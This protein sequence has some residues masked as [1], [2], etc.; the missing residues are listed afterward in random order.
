MLCAIGCLHVAW[1]AGLRWGK[2]AVIPT[3]AGRPTLRPGRTATLVIGFLLLLAAD[4]Y[5]GAAD[6]RAPHL[7]YRLGPVAVAVV[8]AGRAV[9]D[10]RT[11]GFTKQ[12]N[13]TAFARLDTRW[14]TPLCVVLAVCGLL[15]ATG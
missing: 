7:L 2:D 3:V 4:M 12:V 15:V 1:A 10:R 13:D 6:G 9:G 5:V 8:L 11:F 14:L